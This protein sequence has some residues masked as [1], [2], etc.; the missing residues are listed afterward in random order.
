MSRFRKMSGID[1][2]IGAFEIKFP[3]SNFR[4]RI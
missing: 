3:I 4:D 2:E 1:F